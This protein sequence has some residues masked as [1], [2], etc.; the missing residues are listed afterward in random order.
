MIHQKQGCPVAAAAVTT[1][2][3]LSPP[4]SPLGC[5]LHANSCDAAAADGGSEPDDGNTD[6]VGT[7]TDDL[8]CFLSQ[9]VTTESAVDDASYLREMECYVNKA[10]PPP[11]RAYLSAWY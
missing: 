5:T 10:N 2:C 3:T 1:A 11:C 4:A 6:D 8:R 9:D 7:L